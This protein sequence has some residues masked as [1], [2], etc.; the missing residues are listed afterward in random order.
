LI[1]FFKREYVPFSSGKKQHRAS[2]VSFDSR[3]NHSYHT[4]VEEYRFFSDFI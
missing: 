4:I 3:N 1:H 2:P